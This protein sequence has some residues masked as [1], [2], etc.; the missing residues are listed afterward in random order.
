VVK[1]RKKLLINFGEFVK[2]MFYD[3]SINSDFKFDIMEVDKNHIHLL[4][5]YKPTITVKSIINRLKSVSTKK[6]WQQHQ[7]VLKSHFWKEHT[8]WSSGYFVC[9]V[10]D[11]SIETIRKYIE[12]QG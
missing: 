8:F 2:Q 10:G 6:L 5:D 9:S 11:A 1:Y 7:E 12:E 4:I 3:I